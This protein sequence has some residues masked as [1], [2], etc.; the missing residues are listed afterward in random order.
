MCFKKFSFISLLLGY[1]VIGM[2]QA[3]E[4]E[5]TGT[6]APE[7]QI[8]GNVIN[9]GMS[10]GGDAELEVSI[11]T[12]HGNAKVNDFKPVISI[13]D[14]ALQSSIVN[15]GMAVGGDLCAKVSIGTMGAGT[16]SMGAMHHGVR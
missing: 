9:A 2:A 16:C 11:G 3:P 1:Y 4:P 12:L 13:G 7:I 14:G 10:I 5:V 8:E 6:F 15:A